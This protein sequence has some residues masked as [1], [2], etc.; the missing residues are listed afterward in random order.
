VVRANHGSGV[1]TYFITDDNFARNRNWEAILDR[2]TDLREKHRFRI[3]LTIQVDTLC[4][5]IPR[6]VEKAARA[7]C[8]RVFIGLENINPDS[9]RGAS[10]GQNR[11]TEYR[12][13]LQA[14]RKVGVLTYAGYILGFPSD[15]PE[16]IARDIAI[17]Q[18]ELPIDMLEFFVLTPLPGSRDHQQMLA[19][20]ERL[21][22]DLNR[23][24]AEHVTADHALMTAEQW[25]SI[26]ERAW[27]LYYSPEH[28]E[29]LIK[30]A[31]GAHISAARLTSMIFTFYASHA[32]ERVH[33]L[34]SGVLRRKRR[35]DRRS[36][37]PQESALIFYPRRVWELV[38]AY[39]PAMLFLWRLTRLRHRL[40]RDPATRLYR[41]LATSPLE[42][43]LAGTLGLFKAT[44]GA[45]KAADQARVRAAAEKLRTRAAMD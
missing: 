29:T 39:L 43:E 14:W 42:N 32:F 20:G 40:E 25:Q 33:P 34:Q 24:D 22:P 18:R 17:I 36:S 7:G 1:T 15:T 8:K 9:L 31:I 30:R 11:I 3:H 27:H 23:Y 16:S 19:R 13:M 10:K 28:I 21:H 26:Y 2:I 38:R 5:K 12:A 4:H 44:E 37:L 41:D 6:F 45:R 35:K